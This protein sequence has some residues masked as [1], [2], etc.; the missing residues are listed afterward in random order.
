VVRQ[1]EIAVYGVMSYQVAQRRREF[2]IRLTL[3]A[4]ARDLVRLVVVRGAVIAAGGAL[5][6]VV[7]AAAVTHLLA[8]QLFGLSPHDPVTF[9]VV[10][11]TLAGVAVLASWVPARR[12]LRVDPAVSLRPD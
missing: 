8:S 6:G 7:L 10:A 4:S 3:G 2:G 9:G 5:T 1:R 12:A 11:L